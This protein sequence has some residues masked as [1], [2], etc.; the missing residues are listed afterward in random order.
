M[1]LAKGVKRWYG[2]RVDG[3]F[4]QRDVQIQMGDMTKNQDWE[5]FLEQ[6]RRLSKTR[7]WL[8]DWVV[9]WVF[10]WILS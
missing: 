1:A 9:N 2:R 3:Y 7:V 6:Q 8:T 5:K 10:Y 4:S